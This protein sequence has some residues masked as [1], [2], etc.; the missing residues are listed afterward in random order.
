[1]SITPTEKRLDIW[2]D[3]LWEPIIQQFLDIDAENPLW[4]VVASSCVASLHHWRCLL[5]NR[6]DS[7]NQNVDR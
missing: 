3:N 7:I 5:M 6:K 4:K 1:M 2:D